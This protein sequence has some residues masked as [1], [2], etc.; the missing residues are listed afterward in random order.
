MGAKLP[1]LRPPLAHLSVA[2]LEIYQFGYSGGIFA[3]PGHGVV[4]TL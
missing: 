3:L 1:I 2:S 4:D